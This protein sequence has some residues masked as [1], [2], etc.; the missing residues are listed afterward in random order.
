[1]GKVSFEDR[2]NEMRKQINEAAWGRVS[3]TKETT[4]A[5]AHGQENEVFLLC[6]VC[7]YSWWR[8]KLISAKIWA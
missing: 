1:M 3:L 7:L 4:N 5:K 8:V 2:L 6:F